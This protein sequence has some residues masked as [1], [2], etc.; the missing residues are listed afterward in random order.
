MSRGVHAFTHLPD[1]LKI[2]EDRFSQDVESEGDG[3]ERIVEL[4]P[5]SGDESPERSQ[6]FSLNEVFVPAF[7][8]ATAEGPNTYSVQKGDKTV[9]AVVRQRDGVVGSR[10]DRV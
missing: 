3:G 2:G 4:V 1:C 7:P 6:L 8:L 9:G 5:D 10:G